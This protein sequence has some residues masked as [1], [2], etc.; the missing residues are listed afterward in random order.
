MGAPSSRR[1][2]RGASSSPT[3]LARRKIAREVARFYDDIARAAGFTPGER[4]TA[5]AISI[6]LYDYGDTTVPRK[7]GLSSIGM[8]LTTRSD[9]EH[10][11]TVTASRL[12]SDLF[13]E[14][15]PRTGFQILTRLKAVE[16]REGHEYIDHLIL[17]AAFFSELHADE[18]KA[19]LAEKNI[20]KKTK[21]LRIEEARAR[22]V[23]EALTYLPKCDTKVVT[24]EGETYA[25]M[26]APMAAEFVKANP[27]FKARHYEH[28]PPPPRPN[29]NRPLAIE[30]LER[31]ETQLESTIMSK[32][33]EIADRNSMSEARLFA[34]KL[35]TAISKLVSSWCKASR[36]GRQEDE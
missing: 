16:E 4:R 22:L 31:I 20:D 32:L 2:L 36:A 21:R 12:T 19:I 5:F 35:G 27:E 8:C 34:T 33:E 18:T 15:I 3:Q 25:Y 29:Q 7:V 9:D 10:A 1:D 14:A 24:A 17:A 28:S 6:N 23:T 26:P 13:T 30:D 11:R